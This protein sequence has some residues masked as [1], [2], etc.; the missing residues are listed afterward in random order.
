MNEATSAGRPAHVTLHLTVDVWS[1]PRTITGAP[2]LIRALVREVRTGNTMHVKSGAEIGD[3]VR[4][5]L[6]R[7]HPGPHV[8]EGERAG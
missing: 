8:W 5:E 4:R 6:H 1:E 3:F 2:Q 7:I